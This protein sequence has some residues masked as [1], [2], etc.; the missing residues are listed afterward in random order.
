MCEWHTYCICR[1]SVRK[2]KSTVQCFVLYTCVNVYRYWSTKWGKICNVFLIFLLQNNHSRIKSLGS[3]IAALLKSQTLLSSQQWQQWNT[4]DAVGHELELVTTLLV[5][6]LSRR[7]SVKVTSL[8]VREKHRV[9]QQEKKY[10]FYLMLWLLR[11]VA[12]GGG[13]TCFSSPCLSASPCGWKPSVGLLLSHSL[14][15]VWELDW[16]GV[17][18]LSGIELIFFL[19]YCCVLNLVWG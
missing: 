13:R 9:E 6:I 11:C 16:Q 19:V 10:S 18:G 17:L 15:F 14:L 12:Y 8:S 7:N 4:V 5:S 3:N 1:Y 2:G